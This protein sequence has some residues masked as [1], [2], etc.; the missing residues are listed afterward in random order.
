MVDRIEQVELLPPEGVETCNRQSPERE[1][2]EPV[3]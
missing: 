3:L 2:G 1:R